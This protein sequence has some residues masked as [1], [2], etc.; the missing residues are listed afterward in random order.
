MKDAGKA[1][2]ARSGPLRKAAGVEAGR[3]LVELRLDDVSEY[4]RRTGDRRR[5]A[6]FRASASMSLQFLEG[7]GLR[8]RHEA[9]RLQGGAPASHGA[10][11]VHRKPGSVGQCATPSRVSSGAARMLGPGRMGNDQGHHAQPRGRQERSL[12]AEVLLVRGSVPGPR[13]RHRGHPRRSEGFLTWL[14]QRR[15]KP[16]PPPS[17]QLPRKPPRKRPKRSPARPRTDLIAGRA[18]LS[19]ELFGI[20]PNIAVMHQ[21]V[22]AQLAAKSARVPTPRRPVPR[23]VVV[24]PSR[25]VRRAP[26]VPAPVH[27]QL[28]DLA[29]WRYRSRPEA[30]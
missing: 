21:V 23:S 13:W 10:H 15:R 1:D 29:W 2:P 19:P 5:P 18:P 22:T 8:R 24:A 17:L 6:R 16:Q 28:A 11:K 12:S 30:P 4:H 7:Q 25:G 20:E 3:K 27:V 9:S 26:A 14:N